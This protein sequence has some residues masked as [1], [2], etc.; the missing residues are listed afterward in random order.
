LWQHKDGWGC[1]ESAQTGNLRGSFQIVGEGKEANQGALG[2]MIILSPYFLEMRTNIL[3]L[4]NALK[5][6]LTIK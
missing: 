2:L 1:P 6:Y 4:S 3:L 5:H